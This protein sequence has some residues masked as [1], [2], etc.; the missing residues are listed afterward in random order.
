MMLMR[1]AHEE[2]IDRVPMR[3]RTKDTPTTKR[4]TTASAW[5]RIRLA[6]EWFLKLPVP[7]VLLVMW[8]AGVVLLGACTLVVYAVLSTLAGW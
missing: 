1:Q 2:V 8:V 3:G 4:R 6:Y 5:V 7:V